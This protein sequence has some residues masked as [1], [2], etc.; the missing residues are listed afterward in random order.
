MRYLSCLLP[1]GVFK[2]IAA[3]LC[4]TGIDSEVQFMSQARQFQDVFFGYYVQN[5]IFSSYAYFT[6]QNENTFPNRRPVFVGDVQQFEHQSVDV[7]IAVARV[8]DCR[9]EFCEYC[10][11]ADLA[12]R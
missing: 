12:G 1:A 11:S 2:Y 7:G 10:R 9:A 8:P 3:S 6:S 5:R 4:R